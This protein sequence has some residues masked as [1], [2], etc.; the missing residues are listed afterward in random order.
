MIA[1]AVMS[2]M[3]A[4]LGTRITDEMMVY[5]DLI[6]QLDWLFEAIAEGVMPEIPDELKAE[7]M[8]RL[9]EIKAEFEARL[10]E[11]KAELEARLPEIRVELEAKMPKILEKLDELLSKALI[12]GK[13][14]Q[15][16]IDK[17]KAAIES[18][19]IPAE[20][21][22]GL[23]TEELKAEIQAKLPEMRA[24]IQARWP[25]IH[26]QLQVRWPEIQAEIEAKLPELQAYIGDHHDE[27]IE[28]IA[29]GMGISKD[30]ISIIMASTSE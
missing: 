1:S 26:E 27:I 16:Q 5:H 7:I 21:P 18:F 14:T 22:D 23:F 12:D 19:E 25:E 6:G 10:P 3:Q 28:L 4:T 11:I 17:A 8:A 24:E 15:D 2:E 20:F 30:R 13:I 9:P 29:Q